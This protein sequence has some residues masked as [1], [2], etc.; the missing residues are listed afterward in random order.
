MGRDTTRREILRTT[1]GVIAGVTGRPP[2]EG[3]PTAVMRAVLEDRPVP[4]SEV[5]DVP[6]RLD[7]ILSTALA[8][9]KDER[10]DNVAY[11]RDPYDGL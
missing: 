5:A 7:V 2:F 6:E 4:P 3:Q 8:E 10:Y 11:L 9:R 1:G